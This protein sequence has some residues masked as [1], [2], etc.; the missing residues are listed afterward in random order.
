[1][2]TKPEIKAV[3]FYFTIILLSWSGSALAAFGGPVPV[4]LMFLLDK[5]LAVGTNLYQ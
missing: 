2:P 4:L 1:M 5:T 3:L